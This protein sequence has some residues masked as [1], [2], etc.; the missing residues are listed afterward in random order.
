MLGS[1]AR[2]EKVV[3]LSAAHITNWDIN[4]RYATFFLLISACRDFRYRSVT[5]RLVGKLYFI[6]HTHSDANQIFKHFSESERWSLLASHIFTAITSFMH[7][8]FSAHS[9]ASLHICCVRPRLVC[10]TVSPTLSFSVLPLP[11]YY[12]ISSY[13]TLSTAFFIPRSS[14]LLFWYEHFWCLIILI[15]ILFLRRDGRKRKH[16]SCCFMIFS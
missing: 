1:R 16:I 12:D 11:F 8:E 7:Y 5:P 6:M 10:I 13:E 14:L 2:D 15:K 3:V 4:Y 9:H